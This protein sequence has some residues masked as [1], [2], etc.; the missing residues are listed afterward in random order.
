MTKKY[1]LTP[2]QKKKYAE[3]AKMNYS[4]L[5]DEEKEIKKILSKKYRQKNKDKLKQKRKAYHKLKM[6]DP[7]YRQKRKESKKLSKKRMKEKDPIFGL[8][9]HIKDS[10]RNRGIDAPHTPLEYK[11]WYIKQIK[12]CHFC[13][14]TDQT[15]RNYLKLKDE[16]ITNNQNRLQIERMDSSKGYLLDNL[17]L[18][19]SICNTHKS[20]IISAEDFK[21]IAELYIAP[22]IKKKI[23]QTR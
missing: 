12:I 1:I 16:K 15:I 11:N 19:C 7:D 5:T 13:G 17:A 10:A 21:E 8:G 22:K 20:D 2:E 14:N 9:E 6:L 23:S 18:A 3:K 4:N